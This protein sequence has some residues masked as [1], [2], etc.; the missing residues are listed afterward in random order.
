MD[1]LLCDFDTKNRAIKNLGAFSSTYMSKEAEEIFIKFSSINAVDSCAYPEIEEM[2]QYCG[3]FLLD[4][5][6]ACS[7]KRYQFFPTSGSS[8]AIFLAILLFKNHWKTHHPDSTIKP[9]LIIHQTSHVAFISAARALDVAI[10]IIKKDYESFTWN[11]S[12]L[13]ENIDKGTIGVVCTLGATTTLVMDEVEKINAVLESISEHSDYLIPIHVDAASGGF[14]A[15]FVH[16]DFIWDFRLS[17]VK[18]INVSSHKYG[19]V[20]PSLGWLCVDETICDDNLKNENTYLGKSMK[21]LPLHFSHSASHVATQ[22][23]YFNS[24]GWSG[25]SQIVKDLYQKNKFIVDGLKQL[26]ELKIITPN[27]LFS[28]PG[29]I[30]QASNEKH[31]GLQA[32]SRHLIKLGWHLPVFNSNVVDQC[33]SQTTSETWSARIVI[34]YG[35]TEAFIDQL[36]ADIKKYFSSKFY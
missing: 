2:S 9:N 21:R 28:I 10:K 22:F 15:P 12:Q 27:H 34:R 36:L 29:V 18:S 24:L 16:S 31:G 4:M 19:L 30:M 33:I 5:F 7:P 6:H 14:I 20:Y 11:L 3:N 8:E 25:Y 35:L 13:K 17:H 26:S 32:L 23:Y 1:D